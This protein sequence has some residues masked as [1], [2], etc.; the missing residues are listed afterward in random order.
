M[1]LGEELDVMVQKYV[2]ALRTSV[3]SI[4]TN[5]VMAAVSGI[6]MAY[7]RTLITVD[8]FQLQNI[9]LFLHILCVYAKNNNAI[10]SEVVEVQHTIKTHPTVVERNDRNGI[11]SEE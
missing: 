4:C 10:K 8:I 1:L 5:M 7:D 3:T 2:K 9:G 11:G 6:I